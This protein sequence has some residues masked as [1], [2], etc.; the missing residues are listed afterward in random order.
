MISIVVPVYNEEKIIK[1]SF[2]QIKETMDTINEPYEI[3]FV[4]DGS[5]DNTLQE[6]T[7]LQ[8]KSKNLRIISY[9]PNKGPGAAFR[10]GFK[11][12]KGDKIITIDADL[13]FSPKDIPRLLEELKDDV[14]VVL[15][16]QHMKGAKMENIP[17]IRVMASKSAVFLDRRRLN[18]KLST[19]SS[20]FALYKADVIKNVEFTENGFS[21]QPEILTTLYRNK[22]NIKEIPCTLRWSDKK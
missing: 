13:S 15:G 22:V 11:K 2:N 16:S 14:Q 18:V 3:V 17:W 1:Y 6:L 8:K 7:E 19:L 10:E 4:N 20:F 12:A 21:A 9:T 5:S